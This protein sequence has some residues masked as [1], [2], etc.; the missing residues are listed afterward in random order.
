[1]IAAPPVAIEL[2]VPRRRTLDGVVLFEL[3]RLRPGDVTWNSRFRSTSVARTALDLAMRYEH[4]ALVRMLAEAEFKHDLRPEDVLRT[5]RRGHPGS[6]HLRAALAAHVPGHGEAKSDLERR[7]RRLLI[8]H[9]IALPLRNEAIGPYEVDCL[10]PDRR[11]M[12]EL[13]ARQHERSAQA[14]RDDDRDLWLR[15]NR[16]VVRRYG[17]KQ[18]KHQPDAVIADLLDAFAEPRLRQ[19]CR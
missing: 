19:A 14:D 16:Y 18:L 10:W 3:G 13:D 15:R 4:P 17:T 7:F 8:T 11:V 6:A 9:D 12:V 1:M 2:A 5:L